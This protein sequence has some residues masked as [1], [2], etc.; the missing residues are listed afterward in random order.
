[1]SHF[2][3]H[4]IEI[5]I[6]K[7]FLF[8]YRFLACLKKEIEFEEDEIDLYSKS[9]TKSRDTTIKL[10]ERVMKVKP[11]ETT[12]TL[13]LNEA[14]NYV[15]ALSKPMEEAVGLINANLRAVERQKEELQAFDADIK[16]FQEQLNFKGFDLE[17][18]ELEYPMTV[19]A[20]DGCKEYE[21]VGESR[22]RNVIYSQICHD[23]CY[24]SGV[25]VET[26]NNE[27]LRTCRAMEDGKC[28]ECQHDFRRHMH[29]TYKASLVEKEFLCKEAQ[30]LI[31][32]KE[33]KKS[34]KEAVVAALEETIQELKKEKEYIFECASYFGVFLNENA[35]IPYNDSF[36]DYL[37]MLIQ[38]E[39]GKKKNIRDQKNIKKM[40]K[41]KETYEE[42]KRIIEQ[43]IGGNIADKSKVVST[44]I[45]KRKD[46]LCSLKHNGKSLERAL[47]TVLHIPSFI[48]TLLHKSRRRSQWGLLLTIKK[49]PKKK[50]NRRTSKDYHRQSSKHLINIS[51]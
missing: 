1:M 17:I 7:I 29:I 32:E 33:D 22:E 28:K 39:E 16:A 36:S 2:V 19:C 10:F 14:R 38:D 6:Y 31:M 24:L 34:Q 44:D 35:L 11:H 40:K 20:A 41:E 23:H 48:F 37:D 30:Q 46:Q 51:R 13:S 12:K 9:W 47:G 25:S 5:W 4:F 8:L 45:Y 21:T 18:E 49:Y 50:N 26:M 27:Q 42:K 3:S 43:N 15:L